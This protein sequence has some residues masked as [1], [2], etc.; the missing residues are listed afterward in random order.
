[1]DAWLF[2]P[3]VENSVDV[4]A[5]GVYPLVCPAYGL[6][7]VAYH[8]LLDICTAHGFVASFSFQ[9]AWLATFGL[10]DP[11]VKDGID[12]LAGGVNPPV[13]P[14]H[15]LPHVTHYCLPDVGSSLHL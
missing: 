11:H 10:A 4:F 14:A 3:H 5:G 6:T 2:D 15:R 12:V 1:M 8:K 9:P 7:N 13:Y